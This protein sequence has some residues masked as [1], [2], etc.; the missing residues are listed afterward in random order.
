MAPR[1]AACGV[2]PNPP[3]LPPQSM[4][5]ETLPV[6]HQGSCGDVVAACF[7][8]PQLWNRLQIHH[9]TLN[10]RLH[11]VDGSAD[12][13]KY[14]LQVGSGETTSADAHLTLDA[15]MSCGSTLESL[16]T[17]IYPSIDNV[18]TDAYFV[19]RAILA[20]RNDDVD[21]VD[22]Q[23][24]ATFPGQEKIYYAQ[25]KVVNEGQTTFQNGQTIED[26]YPCEFLK[27]V[28]AS[29]HFQTLP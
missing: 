27:S 29:G 1:L 25:D 16:I 11:D 26:L 8:K 13:A 6:I 19:D 15:D 28:K 5:I 4:D 3:A 18:Q 24:L 2:N 17:A 20:C 10:F 12:W 21:D 23:L 22:D 7:N 9:L 14:L